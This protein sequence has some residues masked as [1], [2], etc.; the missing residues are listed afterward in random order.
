MTRSAIRGPNAARTG[1]V[2]PS[3]REPS[4]VI[5]RSPPGATVCIVRIFVEEADSL[6]CPQRPKHK[7][8]SYGQQEGRVGLRLQG[9]VDAL[10]KIVADL[11]YRFDRFPSLVLDV[12]DDPSGLFCG[13]ARCRHCFTRCMKSLCARTAGERRKFPAQVLASAEASAAVPGLVNNHVPAALGSWPWPII[14]VSIRSSSS[15]AKRRG[16]RQPLR[17]PES[18]GTARLI[19]RFPAGATFCFDRLSVWRRPEWPRS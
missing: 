5:A 16:R 14:Q 3:G 10:L 4:H 17:I 13:Y 12:G 9:L 11:S 1:G 2:P 15:S 6:P 8:N 19:A 7:T 18:S